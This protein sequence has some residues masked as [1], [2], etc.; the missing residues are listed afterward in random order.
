MDPRM[1]GFVPTETTLWSTT[2]L[3]LSLL[4]KFPIYI[5]DFEAKWNNWQQAIL[6]EELAPSITIN[7]FFHQLINLTHSPSTW[8][9]DPSF[10]ALFALGPKIIPLVVYQLACNPFNITAV[11]LCTSSSSLC[12]FF[13]PV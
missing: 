3:Y 10:R 4:E 11:H 6:I 7:T 1:T 2:R 5:Q 12:S 9:S 8:S 13:S